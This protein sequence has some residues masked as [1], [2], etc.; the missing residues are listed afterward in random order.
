MSFEFNFLV[1]VLGIAFALL[2]KLHVYFK[3]QNDDL[4]FKIE[5][6][7]AW[8]KLAEKILKAQVKG[9][10]NNDFTKLA[11]CLLSAIE[12]DQISVAVNNKERPRKVVDCHIFYD[13]VVLELEKPK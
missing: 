13:S 12:K 5:K 7:E 11:N 3:K 9:T 2:W 10:T 6:L 8:R 1:A 4:S